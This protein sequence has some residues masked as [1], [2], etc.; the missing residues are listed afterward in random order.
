MIDNGFSFFTQ[1][2]P[3]NLQKAAWLESDVCEWSLLTIFDNYWQLTIQKNVRT[4]SL[5]WVFT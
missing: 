3:V 5:Q 4:L 2:R 1:I